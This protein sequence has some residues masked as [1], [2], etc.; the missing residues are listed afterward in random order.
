MPSVSGEVTVKEQFC[1]GVLTVSDME[2]RLDTG[3]DKEMLHGE[4]ATFS[5]AGAALLPF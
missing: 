4:E 2:S 3:S 1:P 5:S